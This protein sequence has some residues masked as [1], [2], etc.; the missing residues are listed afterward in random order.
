LT[1]NVSTFYLIYAIFASG[2]EH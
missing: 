1:E 2:L